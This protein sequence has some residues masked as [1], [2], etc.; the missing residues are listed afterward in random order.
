[1]KKCIAFAIGLIISGLMFV[2]LTFIG[3]S[4]SQ[5]QT[6]RVVPDSCLG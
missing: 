2:G 5:K 3:C 4:N 6:S 1:M